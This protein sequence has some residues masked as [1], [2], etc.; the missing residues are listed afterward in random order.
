L[1]YRNQILLIYSLG[2]S[3]PPMIK[4]VPPAIAEFH[5]NLRPRSLF[6]QQTPCIIDRFNAYQRFRSNA[7][8]HH[9][10]RK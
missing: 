10:P 3:N 4:L 1:N 8:L 7:A 6:P 2:P 5:A 9:Q